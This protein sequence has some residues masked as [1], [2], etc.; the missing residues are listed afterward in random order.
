MPDDIRD[1]D[2]QSA[3]RQLW[4]YLDGE[5][6]DERM[7]E[8][9]RHLEHCERCLPH[10]DFGR[11]FLEALHASRRRQLIPPE[12]RQHVLAALGAEGFGHA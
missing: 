7:V 3:V 5:L 11:R 2:C 1:I 8:V 4:D 12:V 10:E 9:R 6:S